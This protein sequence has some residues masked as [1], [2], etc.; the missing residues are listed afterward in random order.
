M[1]SAAGGRDDQSDSE[2][3]GG[4]KHWSYLDLFQGALTRV[5]SMYRYS[6]ESGEF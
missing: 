4:S 3:R 1:T 2:Y 6:S 5:W